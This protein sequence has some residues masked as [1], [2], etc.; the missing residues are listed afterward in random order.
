MS[1]F[2]VYHF[3]VPYYYHHYYYHS[4]LLLYFT[5]FLIIKLFLF[6]H[7]SFILILLLIPPKWGEGRVGIE[8]AAMWCLVFSCAWNHDTWIAKLFCVH[9]L[10][11]TH[12]I[13]SAWTSC[14]VSCFLA[15][16]VLFWPNFIILWYCESHKREIDQKKK[17]S[18]ELGMKSDIN[19]LSLYC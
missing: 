13:L 18:S 15:R 5:L 16:E 1:N 17:K 6:Q 9:L 4:P 3:F 2:I 12:L 14:K 8:W 11:F 7:K 10:P 19:L